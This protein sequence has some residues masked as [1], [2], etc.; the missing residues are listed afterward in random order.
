MRLE[1]F[2][3]LL[4]LL[5]YRYIPPPPLSAMSDLSETSGRPSVSSI[6]QLQGTIPSLTATQ[7]RRRSSHS[8]DERTGG[9]KSTSSRRRPGIRK[10][11]TLGPN[12][13][14][15]RGDTSN[16]QRSTSPTQMSP[17]SGSVHYTRTGRISKAKKGLK[18]HHCD[19]GRVSTGF[20]CSATP[21]LGLF[22]TICHRAASWHSLVVYNAPPAP[23]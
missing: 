2:P 14:S 12:N 5:E 11:A 8:S 21:R 7:R 13:P 6:Q 18:V 20:S 1:S 17:D 23:A 3:S 10:E 16:M 22:N 9:T 4:P 15:S 19:C